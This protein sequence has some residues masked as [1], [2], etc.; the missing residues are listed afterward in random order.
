MLSLSLGL[1]S[2][3][4]RPVH[5]MTREDFLQIAAWRTSHLLEAT[6]YS[7][8]L[9][10]EII[11]QIGFSQLSQIPEVSEHAIRVLNDFLLL[12]SSVL[13]WFKTEL[14][15][16]CEG[17]FRNS[18]YGMDGAPRQPGQTEYEA[19]QDLF[20]IY[21]QESAFAGSVAKYVFIDNANQE[22]SW[23]YLEFETPW[24]HEHRLIFIFRNGQPHA[25][26]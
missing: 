9:E 12:D 24:D 17:A 23:F 14:W 1:I 25:V 10:R 19:N 3:L 8:A 6:V 20:G 16:A 21:D 18:S 11:V 26:E 2:L 7:P 13:N 22:E 15:N 4:I 5:Q